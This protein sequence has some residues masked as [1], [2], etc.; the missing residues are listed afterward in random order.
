[1]ILELQEEIINIKMIKH[2]M[3]E[4]SGIKIITKYIRKIKRIIGK[5]RDSVYR[6]GGYRGG[7]YSLSWPPKNRQMV[8]R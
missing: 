2:M 7:L 6:K 1:M 5:R 4:K 3:M 8:L